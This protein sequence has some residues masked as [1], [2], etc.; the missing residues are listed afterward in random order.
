MKTTGRILTASGLAITAAVWSPAFSCT[1]ERSR[2]TAQAGWGH[3]LLHAASA[4]LNAGIAWAGVGA[5]L[6]GALAGSVTKL[7][8]GEFEDG[9]ATG[10][11][12]GTAAGFATGVIYHGDERAVPV[13]AAASRPRC[14]SQRKVAL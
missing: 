10:A 14:D 8:G 1:E 2:V 11:A 3:G 13:A 6:G 12:V 5:E 9:F 7:L 4:R